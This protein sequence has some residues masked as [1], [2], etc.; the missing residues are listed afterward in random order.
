[1]LWVLMQNGG[2]WWVLV[3][4]I[5]V[6]TIVSAFYYFRVIKPMFLESSD[7]PAFTPGPLGMGLGVACAVVLVALFVGW[8]GLTRL[9]THYSR[10]R[11]AGDAA[12]TARAATQPAAPSPVA[13][14]R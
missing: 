8:N 13:A 14:A 1:V 7:A 10:L 11:P 4:V 12:T 9:S 3:A 5:G 2:W 6:N